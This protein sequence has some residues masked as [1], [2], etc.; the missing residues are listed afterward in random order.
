MR[1]SFE[2]EFYE[3]PKP[4]IILSVVEQIRFLLEEQKISFNRDIPLE[5]DIPYCEMKEE[6]VHDGI[7]SIEE[8]KNGLKKNNDI[9]KKLENSFNIEGNQNG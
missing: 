6:M 3:Y 8:Y 2:V 7:M 9:I 5:F 4:S 1:I